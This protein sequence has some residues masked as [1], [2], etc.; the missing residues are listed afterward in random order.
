MM[1]VKKVSDTELHREDPRPN[2]RPTV[3]LTILSNGNILLVVLAFTKILVK[4]LSLM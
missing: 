2:F 3:K 4:P 1:K